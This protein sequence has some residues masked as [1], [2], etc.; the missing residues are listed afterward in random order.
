MLLTCSLI[1]F[2]KQ[3]VCF[4]VLKTLSFSGGLLKNLLPTPGIKLVTFRKV[5][6]SGKVTS[7]PEKLVI[8]KENKIRF[9]SLLRPIQL[10]ITITIQP[11]SLVQHRLQL[12]APTIFWGA[13]EFASS[14]SYPN[15]GFVLKAGLIKSYLQ[16]YE[17]VHNRV[18]RY[19]IQNTTCKKCV[20]KT[21]LY[22]YD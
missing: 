16:F 10:N 15:K 17:L 14:L 7:W 13:F 12:Y 9:V 18:I 2:L 5:E 8:V 11:R 4:S 20:Y 22:I 21:F 1:K 3:E 19:N 6:R